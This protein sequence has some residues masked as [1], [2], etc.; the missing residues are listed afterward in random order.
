MNYIEIFKYISNLNSTDELK[1][2]YS[3]I[4]N[5]QNEHFIPAVT[6]E[7]AVFLKWITSI[8][9]PE[10]ILEIG[11]GAGASSFFIYNGYKESS[12]FI[13]LEKDLNRYNRGMNLLNKYNNN[14]IK[15][16]NN[17]AFVFLEENAK[18]FDFIFLDAVKREYIIYYD[19]LKSILNHNGILICDNILFGGKV[20][21]NEIEKKYLT[22]VGLLKEF[23]NMLQNDESL[24][25]IFLP[26][27]D[28]LSCSVKI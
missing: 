15:L 18:N 4:I 24:N 3:D 10:K 22:G 7:I 25:T 2:L 26:I 14:S 28:G 21:E 8:L 5:F 1:N 13:T 23:N 12:L 20:V 27:G 19:K 6:Y 11:F 17:D 16:L 9:K